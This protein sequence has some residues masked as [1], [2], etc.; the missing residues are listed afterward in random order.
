[1]HALAVGTA[2]HPA[3]V[4]PLHVPPFYGERTAIR[5]AGDAA[6]VCYR[7]ATDGRGTRTAAPSLLPGP[8]LYAGRR[9][10]LPT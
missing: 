4:L 8:K 2:P 5:P 1:M 10:H 7:R 6:V 3:A 9:H